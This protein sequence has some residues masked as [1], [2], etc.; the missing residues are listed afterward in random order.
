[1]GEEVHPT[2]AHHLDV[3][4]ARAQNPFDVSDAVLTRLDSAVMFQT[5]L[6]GWRHRSTPPPTLRCSSFRHVFLLADGGS[7]VLWEL[8]YQS[9]GGG[10]ELYELYTSQEALRRSERRVHQRLDGAG[11]T[12]EPD[13]EPDGPYRLDGP[14]GPGGPEGPGGL[15]GLDGLGGLSGLEELANLAEPCPTEWHSGLTEHDSPEHARRLLRRAENADRPGEDT[16]RLL[17]TALGYQITHVPGPVMR[18]GGSRVWCSLYEHLF[19]LPDGREVSLY[20]LEHNL[21]GTGRLVCEVYLEEAG[22]DRAV[23]RRARDHGIDL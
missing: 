16:L 12:V 3:L 21:S 20:E 8:C 6:Y 10:H 1:M 18:T 13:A 17:T 19:L 11:H 14:H 4:L 9:E 2:P 22:A 15:D 23:H 5:E 7:L